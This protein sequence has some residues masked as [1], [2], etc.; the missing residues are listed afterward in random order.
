VLWICISRRDESA[1]RQSAP[2]RIALANN[3]TGFCP[4]KSATAH[5]LGVLFT[6]ACAAKQ[7]LVESPESKTLANAQMAVENSCE[8]CCQKLNTSANYELDH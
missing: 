6:T 7:P 2:T 3:G 4:V 5:I 8:A 1:A